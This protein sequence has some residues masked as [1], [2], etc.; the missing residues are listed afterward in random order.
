MH[1]IISSPVVSSGPRAE[2]AGSW[3]V[4]RKKFGPR[5]FDDEEEDIVFK[6]LRVGEACAPKRNDSEEVER[7][8]F[9]SAP[10]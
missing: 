3:L 4:C 7:G 2:S 1:R 5:Y 8:A 9:E 6:D 10:Q